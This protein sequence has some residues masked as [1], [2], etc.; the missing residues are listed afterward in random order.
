MGVRFPTRS[1]VKRSET[2]GIML[3]SLDINYVQMLYMP[4][5]LNTKLYFVAVEILRVSLLV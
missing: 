2:R 1:L 4:V 3:D 5:L